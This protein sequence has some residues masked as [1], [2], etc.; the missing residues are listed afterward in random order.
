MS[1]A[2]T[3]AAGRHLDQID[4]VRT[5][6]CL[7]VIAVHVVANTNPIQDVGANATSVVLHYSREVFFF[8]SALV[9]VHAVRRRLTPQ[10]TLPDPTAFR[11]RR[12]TLIGTPYLFWSVA[13]L[14]LWALVQQPGSVRPQEAPWAL[15]HALYSGTGG[16]HLYFL[17]VS[18]QFGLAF[19]ALLWLLRRTRGHH[20]ALLAASAA[21]QVA[22]LA[23]YHH[24]WLP[25]GL[26][27]P[28]I[29][30]A[31]L[32]AYQLWLVAGGV[33]ALHLGRFHSWVTGNRTLVVGLALVT[34][35]GAE[36]VYLTAVAAGTQPEFAG[37]TL[38]PATVPWAAAAVA[39]LYL[40][41]VGLTGR[42]LA[43]ARPVFRG[44]ARLSFGMYLVHPL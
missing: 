35:A 5:L 6:S 44:G 3:P 2:P 40:V 30:E 19:P 20:V 29:G 17:L 38:Q 26:W 4:A 22:T 43:W 42:R 7:S 34:V 28:L 23:V 14:A 32:P 41:A 24:V 18:I 11:R 27:R 16:F 12:L 10:G 36:A 21:I 9:L 33:T 31:S 15:A 13:Y 25:D 8:V 39:L 1:D 37:R